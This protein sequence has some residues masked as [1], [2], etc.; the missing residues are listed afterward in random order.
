MTE[1]TVTDRNQPAWEE[2]R[3]PHLPDALVRVPAPVWPLLLVTALT[4]WIHV[5]RARAPGILTPT[6]LLFAALAAVAPVVASLIGVALFLRHPDAWS[7]WPMLVVGVLL[8]AAGQALEL[9]APVVR[10]WLEGLAPGDSDQLLPGPLSFALSTLPTLVEAFALL[11]LAHGLARA[12]I[13]IEPWRDRGVI[14]L[15]LGVG[16]VPPIVSV[17]TV[18]VGWDDFSTPLPYLAVSLAAQTFLWLAAPW[19]AVVLIVGARAGE[20]PVAGWWAPAVG[21][22]LRMVA[23][24]VIAIMSL[25]QLAGGAIEPVPWSMALGNAL[26]LAIVLGWILLL[27]GFALGLPAERTAGAR[28]G[29]GSIPGE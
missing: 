14:A 27:V 23:T 17:A 1:S 24:A 16:L 9:V 10:P 6:D 7:R 5:E 15:T 26:S 25:V 20:R 18:F 29:L 8:L 11:Y 22:G 2:P 19:L 13:G 4:L 21:M 3:G 28:A 12:A